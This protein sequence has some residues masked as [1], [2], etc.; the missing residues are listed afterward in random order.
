MELGVLGYSC[1]FNFYDSRH[2]SYEFDRYFNTG[3]E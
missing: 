3:E 1:I 2:W